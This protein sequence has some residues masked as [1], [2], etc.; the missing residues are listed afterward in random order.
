MTRNFDS[1][2]R[3]EITRFWDFESKFQVST[4]NFKFWVEISSF[5]SKFKISTRN[6][7][8]R[9]E[10]SKSR[11]F[12]SKSRNLIISTRNLVI[13]FF[14]MVKKIIF[15]GNRLSATKLTQ[16]NYG[17]SIGDVLTF[18]YSSIIIMRF[19]AKIM[20]FRVEISSRNFES[21]LRDFE[22]SSR[23]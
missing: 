13:T 14:V 12:D 17:N 3:V 10:I 5:D 20:R 23:N 1:K 8:F 9:V 4:R 21:K 15:Y 2:F 22:I 19:R 16:A 7:K 6:L 11:N 18:N